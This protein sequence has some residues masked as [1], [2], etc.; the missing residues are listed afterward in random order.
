[1][2]VLNIPVFIMCLAGSF[3]A[4]Y[5]VRKKKNKENK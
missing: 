2:I 3:L 1:M 4:G 5:I